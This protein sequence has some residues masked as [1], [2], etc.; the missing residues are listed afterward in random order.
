MAMHEIEGGRVYVPYDG[1]D[2]A[3]VEI[4]LSHSRSS[5]NASWA[6]AFLDFK[7]GKRVAWIPEPPH[8]R[9]TE[10]AFLRVNGKIS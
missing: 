8:A 4:G 6:V 2:V 9:I 5:A 10:A 3:K 1:P 7:D